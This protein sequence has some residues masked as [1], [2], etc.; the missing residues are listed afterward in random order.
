MCSCSTAQRP[1]GAGRS[2]NYTVRAKNGTFLDNPEIQIF[3][4]FAK[5]RV[6]CAVYLRRERDSAAFGA[7]QHDAAVLSRC[8]SPRHDPSLEEEQE[9]HHGVARELGARQPLMD[10]RTRASG[11]KPA[12]LRA[13]NTARQPKAP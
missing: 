10:E 3:R 12:D 2:K 11:S 6:Q 13:R 8:E 5:L 4:G 7:A 1:P 9:L